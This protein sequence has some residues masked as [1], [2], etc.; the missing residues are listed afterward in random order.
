MSTLSSGS[1]YGV[2]P[3]KRVMPAPYAPQFP[4]YPPGSL[5]RPFPFLYILMKVS[6]PVPLF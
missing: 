6:R 2:Y 1:T 3:E 4:W 5:V